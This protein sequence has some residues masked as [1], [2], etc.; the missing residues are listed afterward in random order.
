MTQ[1]RSKANASGISSRLYDNPRYYEIAFSFRDIS[2]EVDLFQTCFERFS[3]IPVKSVLELG[4]G[5]CPHM[6]E[7]IKRGYQYSGLDL[8]RAM[9]DYGAQKAGRA[10]ADV[11][12][13]CADM[14][15]FSLN[16]EVDFVY[17]MLGSLSVESTTELSRHF[18]CVAKALKRGG[19][20]LL[21]WCIQFETPWT[22]EGGGT[23]EMERGGVRVKTTV[24]WKPISR[25]DQTFEET[26]IQKVDDHGKKLEIM[27]K[28]VKRA[29]FPQGFL[30]FISGR[31]DF[32]FVGWWNNW[33]LG[34]PLQKADKIDRPVVLVRRK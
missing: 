1:D 19:L 31:R 9:L 27:D 22:T 18:D 10:K 15:D 4:C 32:E 11:N 8:S 6:E 28:D 23:W 26:I 13:I 21:D 7:L 25:V 3:H 17:I 29:I 24:S 2:A 20:Y 5:N 30:F 34:Q 33:D 14:N 12:L 16:K